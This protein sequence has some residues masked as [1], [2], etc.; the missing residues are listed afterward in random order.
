MLRIIV[1][2]FFFLASPFLSF[3]VRST[4]YLDGT[5]RTPTPT[6]EDSPLCCFVSLSLSFGKK[7]VQSFLQ[8]QLSLSFA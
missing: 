8:R 4:P 5:R 6:S 3:L 1:F 7:T 2:F